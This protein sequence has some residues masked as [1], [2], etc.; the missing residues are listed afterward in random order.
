MKVTVVIRYI[1]L[2]IK[3][4]MSAEAALALGT[5]GAVSAAVFSTAKSAL[6]LAVEVGCATV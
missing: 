6:I 3:P 1:G 4:A 5:G 2:V